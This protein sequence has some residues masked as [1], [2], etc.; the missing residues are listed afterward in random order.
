MEHSKIV[1]YHYYTADSAD[2]SNGATT[3]IR[4][5]LLDL[6][7]A[8][9]PSAVDSQQAAIGERIRSHFDGASLWILNNG[10]CCVHVT[11]VVKDNS[12]IGRSAVSKRLTED[13]GKT[14][15]DRYRKA[16]E[17]LG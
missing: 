4:Q 14:Y 12:A 13:E 3:E 2:F 11:Y 10:T 17:A 5:I 6:F 9:A 7:A 16:I 1:H 15:A 8:V